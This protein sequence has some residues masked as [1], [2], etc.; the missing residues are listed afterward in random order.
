MQVQLSSDE[1][2]ALVADELSVLNSYGS[3]NTAGDTGAEGK[4]EE[5]G[6][7]ASK[8][9]EDELDATSSAPQVSS[10]NAISGRIGEKIALNYLQS[11]LLVGRAKK[12][13]DA[14]KGEDEGGSDDEVVVEVVWVN[15]VEEQGAPYD[16]LIR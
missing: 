7:V 10:E 14:D 5:N 6:D 4:G 2:A 8:V 13:T 1:I 15:E 12:A 16:I 9:K 3:T 11:V